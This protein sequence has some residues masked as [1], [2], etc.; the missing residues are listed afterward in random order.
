MSRK[1]R[2]D[3]MFG[4]VCSFC[5]RGL[6]EAIVVPGPDGASIC[7]DCAHQAIEIAEEAR[8]Q[9]GELMGGGAKKRGGAKPLKETAR[10]ESET[11]RSRKRKRLIP[12]EKPPE[13]LN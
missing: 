7:E 9:S 11:A 10:P 6:D 8:R 4:P 2:D 13:A 5:G 12:T 3:A 1:K